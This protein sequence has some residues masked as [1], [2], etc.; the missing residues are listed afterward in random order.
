MGYETTV[1]S[2]G[3]CVYQFQASVNKS[4]LRRECARRS[5][6]QIVEITSYWGGVKNTHEQTPASDVEATSSRPVD[7]TLRN[8]STCLYNEE[9]ILQD[10]DKK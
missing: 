8:S 7:M 9:A 6:Y 1:S 4:N 2:H 5:L 10:E 3:K